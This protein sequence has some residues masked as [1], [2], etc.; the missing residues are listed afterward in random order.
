MDFYTITVSTLGDL[1]AR[2]LL[3]APNILLAILVFLIGLL[4]AT[5]V[6]RLIERLFRAL[7]IDKLL[8][9]LSLDKTVSKTGLKLNSGKFVGEIVRWLV[10]L[11]FLVAVADMLNLAGISEFLNRIILYIPNIIVA[12]IILII[13]TILA[14]FVERL[15]LRSLQAAKYEGY[16]FVAGI[17]KWAILVFALLAAL[18]QLRVAP[19][20]IQVLFTGM[21]AM[22]T[23]A[24]GLAFGLGG[25]DFAKDLLEKLRKD[26]KKRQ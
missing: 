10:I 16:A 19:E 14:Y 23:I 8:N 5:L 22:F 20:I 13:A 21:V 1:W 9:K 4:I 26:F 3:V 24:G 6:A 2:F 7:L 11:V 25:Q 17:A 18:I 15:I 12:V